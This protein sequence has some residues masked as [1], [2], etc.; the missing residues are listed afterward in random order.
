MRKLLVVLAILC[1]FVSTV[2]A[3]K[4]VFGS[5]LD[6]NQQQGQ[7]QERSAAP[8]R[9]RQADLR[10]VRHHEAEQAL[11]DPRDRGAGAWELRLSAVRPAASV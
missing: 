1:M 5:N 2:S 9:D 6:Q 8:R 10:G 11:P 4:T 7:G 3:D